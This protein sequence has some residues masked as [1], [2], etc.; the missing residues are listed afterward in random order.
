MKEEFVK[1]YNKALVIAENRYGAVYKWHNYNINIHDIDES[2]M[3]FQFEEF[4][5][6]CHIGSEYIT[7]GWEELS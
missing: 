1:A 2:G 4:S 3:T 6:G 5:R 7:V